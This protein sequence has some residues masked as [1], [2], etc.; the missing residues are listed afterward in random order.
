[1]EGL[2]IFIGSCINWIIA[3]L[4]VL[5]LIGFAWVVFEIGK[6]DGIMNSKKK[7][8]KKEYTEGGIKKEA[9]VYTWEET[10]DY[11]ESFNRIQLVYSIF[12]QFIP[13]FPL[14]GILGTVAGLIQQL[15][16][17][18]QMRAALALSMST[19]FWGLIAAITLKV[20]DAVLVSKSVNKKA[21]YFEMF[22]QNY[23]MVKDKF[24]QETE[25]GNRG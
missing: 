5:T 13:V 8:R 4:A 3:L 20:V 25:N 11:L 2:A 9:D 23:Q 22:E 12:E 15:G 6:L 18:D 17:V 24:D 10:L 14:L 1:M 19:T 21:L 7:G 16:D